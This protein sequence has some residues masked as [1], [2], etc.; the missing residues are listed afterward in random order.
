[1]AVRYEFYYETPTQQP[2]G[3]GGTITVNVP[4][5]FSLGGI[6]LPVAKAIRAGLVNRAAQAG[7]TNVSATRV[8]DATDNVTDATT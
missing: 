2:D 3:S 7:I 4:T 5:T 1:M 6:A 8:Q